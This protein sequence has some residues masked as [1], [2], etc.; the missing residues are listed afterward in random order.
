M[1]KKG[2]QAEG[3]T[4]VR[5]RLQTLRKIIY[6][7]SIQLNKLYLLLRGIKASR[8]EL[9]KGRRMLFTVDYTD[10]SDLSQL[11]D[12]LSVQEQP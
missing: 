9:R 10:N 6:R 7:D 12:S 1:P 3:A 8:K 5:F 2:A 4:L 11:N